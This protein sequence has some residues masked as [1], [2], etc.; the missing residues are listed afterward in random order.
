[1]ASLGRGR[2]VPEQKLAAVRW[3]E[4]IPAAPRHE[5]TGVVEVALDSTM[6]GIVMMLGAGALYC[7]LAVLG[8]ASLRSRS[9]R[10]NESRFNSGSTNRRAT[11]LCA[12]PGWITLGPTRLRSLMP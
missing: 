9:Q 1:M 10:T 7:M 2:T 11:D 5:R 6:E 4:K 3:V 12:H 8:M